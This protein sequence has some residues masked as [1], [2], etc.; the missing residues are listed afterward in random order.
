M[1]FSPKVKVYYAFII[2]KVQRNTFLNGF[3]TKDLKL[4]NGPKF[5]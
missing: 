5:G 3:S 1:V 4:L 2:Q